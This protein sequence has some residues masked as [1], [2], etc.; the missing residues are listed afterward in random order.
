MRQRGRS[1]AL[2]VVVV[3]VAVAA[4]VVCL[5]GCALL[6]KSEPFTP[7]FF[8]V[9]PASVPPARPAAEGGTPLELRL[10]R[11][12]SAAFLG[13]RIVYRKSPSELGFYEDRRWTEKPEAYLRRS[14]VRAFFD[15]AGFAHVV[16]GG[17][18]QLD[19]DLVEFTELKGPE[20]VARVRAAFALFEARQVCA[21]GTVTA[22]SPVNAAKG[23]AEAEAVVV[24]MSRA[25]DGAVEQIVARVR[26]GLAG[27]GN[28]RAR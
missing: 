20:H 13:E 24:A 15:D 6:T 28:E 11:V 22:E 1:R 9:E 21:E 17:G 7:R 5:G 26:S 3:A 2:V 10:G 23:D 8:S 18:P 14:L 19:V 27:E 4:A 12:T 25:L 16:S